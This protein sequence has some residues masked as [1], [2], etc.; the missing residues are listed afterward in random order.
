MQMRFV[1]PRGK[2]TIEAVDCVR[3]PLLLIQIH[4]LHLISPVNHHFFIL[5][6]T[7]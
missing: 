5:L 2:T 1:V 7:F 3:L 4:H 6:D